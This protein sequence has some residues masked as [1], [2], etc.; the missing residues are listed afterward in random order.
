MYNND[1][2]LI[3]ICELYHNVINTC[4]HI[5]LFN[6]LYELKTLSSR[7]NTNLSLDITSKNLSENLGKFF[8]K[9]YS[10]IK[11]L[12]TNN[13]YKNIICKNI[14]FYD[15]EIL[16]KTSKILGFFCIL[17]EENMQLAAVDFGTRTAIKVE[18]I[19]D[20][21]ITEIDTVLSK[22]ILD[23]YSADIPSEFL[24]PIMNTPI[25]DPV[26]LPSSKVIMNKS[27]ICNHL[28]FNE[29][30]PFNRDPLTLNDLDE[31]N[32]TIEIKTKMSEFLI[33]FNEWKSS[34]KI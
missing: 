32:N 22:D 27:V 23:K 6:E 31:Y 29:Q 16:I 19:I 20:K 25:N 7:T 26:E 11:V 15:K 34:N 3:K 5:R 12:S 17:R 8:K 10:N 28:I 1:N 30:D 13:K 9:L 21:Y 4:F 14:H 24:D 33:Q 2:L 18:Q